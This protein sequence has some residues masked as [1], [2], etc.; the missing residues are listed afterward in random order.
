MTKDIVIGMRVCVLDAANL[1]CEAG[2]T[3]EVVQVRHSARDFPIGVKLDN[4]HG[5]EWF[6]EAELEVLE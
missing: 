3:G 6:R 2:D 1:P 5:V 4:G